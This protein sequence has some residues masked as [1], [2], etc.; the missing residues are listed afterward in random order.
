[1]GRELENSD[2]HLRNSDSALENLRRALENSDRDLGNS[3]RHL[4]NSDSV[5]GFGLPKVVMTLHRIK[6][7]PRVD[8]T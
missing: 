5:S 8:L 7:Y 1:L 4:E 6:I 3:D 2:R